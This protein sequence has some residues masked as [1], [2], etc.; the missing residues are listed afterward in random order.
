MRW[1]SVLCRRVGLALLVSAVILLVVL[2]WR[3][4]SP[5]TGL[6]VAGIAAFLVLTVASILVLPARLVARDTKGASLGNEQRA[7]AINSVRSTLVQGLVGLAALTGIF[8]AWQQLQTDRDRARTDREQLTKQLELTRQ[9]QVA[10]RFTRALDQLASTKLE[11]RLGGIYGLER[12]AKESQT[13]RLQ[14]F[15]VLTAYVRQHVPRDTKAVEST[16]VANM[17]DRAPDVQAAVTV[18]GRRTVMKD[19]PVLDLRRTDLRGAD[20]TGTQ[21]QH[22]LLG[23]AQLQ[24]A[25]LGGAQL[26]EANLVRAQLQ[27]ANLRSAQLQ[28]ATF[29][30]TQLQGANL[31]SA[32]LQGA[33][34]GSAQ[35]QR[36]DLGDAQLQS[37]NLAG[38]QLQGATLRGAQLQGATLRGAQLQGAQDSVGTIWPAGFDGEAEGV[39]RIR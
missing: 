10:E 18:I 6:L 39:R 15:E 28:G 14:V 4:G 12:I 7:N 33:N 32:Q 30:G 8:V 23:D 21:L 34:L 29:V 25:D 22:V 13:T 2:A 36:A 35:L 26:Q 11:Q 1:S 3:L 16:Q 31:R 20:L 24:L 27:G 9:G 19:D 5:N 37:A 38:A 17:R